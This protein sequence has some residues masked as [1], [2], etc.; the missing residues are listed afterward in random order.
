[1][2]GYGRCWKRS[3]PVKVIDPAFIAPAYA[4][5]SV[6]LGLCMQRQCT[7]CF[8]TPAMWNCDIIRQIDIDSPADRLDAGRQ[9]NL[10]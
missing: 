4:E 6:R 7:L 2:A 8:A 10:V 3:F 5:M 1:M 9:R